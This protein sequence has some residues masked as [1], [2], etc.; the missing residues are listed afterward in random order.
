MQNYAIDLFTLRAGSQHTEILRGSDS[1]TVPVNEL[2]LR[3]NLIK[4]VTII[5]EL[6]E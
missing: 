2:I 6:L 5:S 1:I 3:G 4:G